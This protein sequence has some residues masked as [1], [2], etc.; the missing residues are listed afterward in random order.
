MPRIAPGQTVTVNIRYEPMAGFDF[1]P[2]A[3][4]VEISPDI[5]RERMDKAITK[6]DGRNTRTFPKRDER[7][8]CLD[9]KKKIP[10]MLPNCQECNRHV[11]PDCLGLHDVIRHTSM[12][13]L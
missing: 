9:C 1:S 11:C 8:R 12:M 2:T 3:P 6:H 7:V 4:P 13:A 5:A 10:R